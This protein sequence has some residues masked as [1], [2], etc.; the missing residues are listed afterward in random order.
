M[1]NKY[2]GMSNEE[3]NRVELSL[4][5]VKRIT[6]NK[7]EEYK[8][9][10]KVCQTSI[11]ETDKKLEEVREARQHTK[12]ISVCNIICVKK[13][14][15]SKFIGN[16]DNHVAAYYSRR[17]WKDFI[18]YYFN[19]LECNV[20]DHTKSRSSLYAS[21]RYTTEE[22]QNFNTDL[23]T[24]AKQFNVGT[25]YLDDGVKINSTSIKKLNPNIKIIT[26]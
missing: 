17:E 15:E 5:S 21:K 4:N 6:L 3:L 10:I 23:A 16:P 19:V 7:I 18:V 9:N 1:A 12:D 14:T 20:I 24:L 13:E 2:I 22:K 8:Q 11:K 26:K 25:I